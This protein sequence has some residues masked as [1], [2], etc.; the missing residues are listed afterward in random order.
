MYVVV[1]PECFVSTFMIGILSTNTKK[2]TNNDDDDYFGHF[3]ELYMRSPIDVIKEGPPLNCLV[4]R[5]L[6]GYLG[7][8]RMTF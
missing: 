7:I 3:H 2:S 8:F 1:A 5:I 6:I 4:K